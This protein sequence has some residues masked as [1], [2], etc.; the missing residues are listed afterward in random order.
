MIAVTPMDANSSTWDGSLRV[1]T[2]IGQAGL[3]GHLAAGP[4]LRAS[5]Q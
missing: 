5:S 2:A 1:Q 3:G 4:D